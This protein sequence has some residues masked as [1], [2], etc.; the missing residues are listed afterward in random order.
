LHPEELDEGS[1]EEPSFIDELAIRRRRELVN[2]DGEWSPED[3]NRICTTRRATQRRRGPS[4]F[5][6]RLSTTSGATASVTSGSLDRQF[7]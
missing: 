4:T 7:R 3:L 6:P 1:F 2:D 5:Y